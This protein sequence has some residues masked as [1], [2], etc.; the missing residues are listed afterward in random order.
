MR[1]DGPPALSGWRPLGGRKAKGSHTAP[2][3]NPLPPKYSLLGQV[4]ILFSRPGLF[5]AGRKL[6]HRVRIG[7]RALTW[8]GLT[9][10]LGGQL[11]RDTDPGAGGGARW[12]GVHA[13]VLQHWRAARPGGMD[14]GESSQ[15]LQVSHRRGQHRLSRQEAHPLS[16]PCPM[17]AE[18]M[19]GVQGK[20][21]AWPG[22]G[23]R[24]RIWALPAEAQP[25]LEHPTCPLVSWLLYTTTPFPSNLPKARFWQPSTGVHNHCWT[26]FC[27]AEAWAPTTQQHPCGQSKLFIIGM[28]HPHLGCVWD[29]HVHM[30][31][32][33]YRHLP[34]P[35]GLDSVL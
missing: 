10:I 2:F 13:M 28:R 25:A 9:L 5:L 16:Q 30:H 15:V 21:P 32:R 26:T 19:G 12:P 17:G 31:P 22:G 20:W 14:E 11:G 34:T 18:I 1:R 35:E 33:T 24:L 6:R 3:R 7:L 23:T 4:P 27:L 8:A 29:T